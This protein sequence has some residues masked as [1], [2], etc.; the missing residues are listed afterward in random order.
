MKKDIIYGSQISF[1]FIEAR[2][3]QT[4]KAYKDRGHTTAQFFQE[5]KYEQHSILVK[6]QSTGQRL[7]SHTHSVVQKS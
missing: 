6:R 4:F 1:C 7:S 2:I 3:K 5:M